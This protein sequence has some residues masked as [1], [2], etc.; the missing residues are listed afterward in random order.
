MNWHD[1][2]P[3]AH[4]VFDFLEC[5]VILT[6]G[7][8][9]IV[10]ANEIASYL[11]GISE[12]ELSRMTV[13]QLCVDLADRIRDPPAIVKEQRMLATSASQV[14]CEEF[15]IAEPNRS[16]VRWVARTVDSPLAT[17]MIVL[18]DITVEVD[19]RLGYERLAFG[20]R[21]TGLPN[22]RAGELAL[23]SEVARA[24]RYGFPLSIALLDLD[25]FKSVNDSHGHSAGDAVLQAA[26]RVISSSIRETDSV[27][28]WGGEEFLLLMP[29]T[30][31]AGAV[32]CAE[33]V[34]ATVSASISSPGGPVTVSIGVAQCHAGTTTQELLTHADERLYAAKSAGRNL[35]RS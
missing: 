8:S 21:L 16:V 15:E 28:R 33:R 13:G 24:E 6:D 14:V 11:L 18:S 25:H 23:Q 27:F 12:P 30:N 31:V 10:F 22:R 2:S 26:A 4:A 5:G 17:C 9:N 7:N 29:S 1:A 32:V 34:R 35:V 20:D 3:A 19:L